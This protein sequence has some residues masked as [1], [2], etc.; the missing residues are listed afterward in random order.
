[1]PKKC[2]EWEVLRSRRARRWLRRHP[3]AMGYYERVKEVIAADPY[4]GEPLHGR[5]RGLWKLR[6]GRIRLA[7]RVLPEKCMVVVEAVGYREN[8]YEELGC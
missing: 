1:V 3:E 5:C 6:V 4:A 8:I 2:V 7:Y